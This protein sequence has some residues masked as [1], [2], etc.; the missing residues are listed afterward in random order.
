MY[1]LID[2]PL[3]AVDF[4]GNELISINE[5][6]CGSQNYDEMI[7]LIQ[8][9]L[10]TKLNGFKQTLPVDRVLQSQLIN[11]KAISIEQLADLS[12]VSTRQLERQFNERVGMSPKLYFRL[13]R[14]SKAWNLREWYPNISWSAISHRCGYADQTHMIRDFKEFAGVTPGFLQTALEKTPLRLQRDS[15]EIL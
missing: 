13:G 8:R 6:L 1:E 9:Y 2:Q 11:G 12:C 4:L 5:Q 7:M 3:N 15:F 14:F 10:L